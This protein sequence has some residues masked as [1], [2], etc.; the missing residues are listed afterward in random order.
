MLEMARLGRLGDCGTYSCISEGVI[1]TLLERSFDN[2]QRIYVQ[3]SKSEYN[4]YPST[5]LTS[6]VLLQVVCLRRLVNHIDSLQSLR[7]RS[8]RN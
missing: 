6:Y 8:E 3:N 1:N 5:L 4:I 2:G 7:C